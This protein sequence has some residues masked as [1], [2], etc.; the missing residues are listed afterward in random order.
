MHVAVADDQLSAPATDEVSNCLHL[1][2]RALSSLPALP[3]TI[4]FNQPTTRTTAD[5]DRG[6]ARLSGT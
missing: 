2:Q 1:R 6:V 5:T 4:A 3:Q